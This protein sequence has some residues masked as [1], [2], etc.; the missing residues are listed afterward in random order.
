MAGVVT[1]RDYIKKIALLGR[2]S[3]ET[4]IKDIHT[5][6]ANIVSVLPTD[7]I[8]TCMSKMMTKSIRHLPILDSDEKVVGMVSIKDLAKVL[9]EDSERE[10]QALSDF[11]LGKGSGKV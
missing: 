8:E 2:T 7:S 9:V 10:I 3:K 4:P 11:A 5:Q 6:Y 1:E